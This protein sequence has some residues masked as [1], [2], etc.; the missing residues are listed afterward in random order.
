M[1][2]LKQHQREGHTGEAIWKKGIACCVY[3]PLSAMF[4]IHLNAFF[5]CW[6]FL[7]MLRLLLGPDVSSG[8]STSEPLR[9]KS[10]VADSPAPFDLF[11]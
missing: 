11:R 6:G 2:Y 4:L 8:K 10:S 5:W 9:D 3:W 1:L 7:V